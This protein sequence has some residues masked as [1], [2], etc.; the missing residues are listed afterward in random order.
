MYCS[1]LAPTF[2]DFEIYP[3]TA[4][5]WCAVKCHLLCPGDPACGV[6]RPSLSWQS[7]SWWQTSVL[8]LG[9][10]PMSAPAQKQDKLTLVC[11]CRCSVL[12]RLFPSNTVTLFV[13]GYCFV[14]CNCIHCLHFNQR[15]LVNYTGKH[16]TKRNTGTLRNS[17]CYSA[18]FIIHMPSLFF[19][20]GTSH[21]NKAE[22]KD[23]IS[24]HLATL[25]I[26]V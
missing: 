4:A 2:R 23:A 5:S 10:I 19:V 18:I 9:W 14:K 21:C 15:H 22:R 7:S 24:W 25:D 13:Q 26:K 6:R 8:L 1:S 17:S 11:N 16:F 20:W 12:D 3:H